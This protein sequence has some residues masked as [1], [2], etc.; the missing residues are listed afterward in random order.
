MYHV[1][2]AILLQRNVC[3]MRINIEKGENIHLKSTHRIEVV[4][5]DLNSLRKEILASCFELHN[6]RT[7]VICDM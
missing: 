3:I 7:H 6:V 2:S 1:E 5:L 4:F